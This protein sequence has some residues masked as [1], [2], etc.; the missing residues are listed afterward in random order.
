MTDGKVLR[1]NL[2]ETSNLLNSENLLTSW[3]CDDGKNLVL[4]QPCTNISIISI[5][6]KEYFLGLSERYNLFCNDHVILSNCTSYTIHDEFLLITTTDNT[7]KCLLKDWD[8]PA[9]LKNKLN[10]LTDI[11]S[12]RIEKST[13]ITSS[14]GSTKVI[15]QMPR[16]NLETIHPRPLMLSHICKHLNKLQYREAFDLAKVH[17]ID[18]NLL[19]DY[20]PKEFLENVQA[21]IE[22]I[23]SPSNLTLFLAS[24]KN[25]DV[26]ATMYP[27]AL[28]KKQ[29]T[30]ISPSPDNKIIVVCDAFRK[31]LE[32]KND[33]KFFLTL[34]ATYAKKGETEDALLRLQ[35]LKDTNKDKSTQ[36]LVD[37]ALNFLLYLVDVNELIDIALGTYNLETALMVSQKS[38]KD[39]KEFLEFY[40]N[41]LKMEENY[42]K[43]KID[44]HLKRYK[45]ALQHLSKC[46]DK[47]AEFLALMKNQRLYTDALHLFPS[48]HPHRMLV[49]KE[50]GRYLME[51]RYFDEAGL[52]F[53]SCG[54][55]ER[56][57]MAYKESLNWQSVLQCA[58]DL[59]YSDNKTVALCQEMSEK[60]KSNHRYLDAAYLLEHYV[61]DIEES[62]VTLIEGCEWNSALF[63]MSKYRRKDIA[64]THLK[65]ALLEH[66]VYLTTHLGQLSNDFHKHYERLKFLRNQKQQQ[67]ELADFVRNREDD[68][69]SETS[70]II[71]DASS[72]AE[73]KSITGSILTKKSSKSRRKH[74]LKKYRLK[75]GSPNEDLAHLA[76]LSE[77]LRKVEAMKDS[78]SDTLKTLIQFSYEDKAKS[79]QT[80]MCALIKEIESEIPN[81]WCHSENSN[82]SSD[83]RFGPDSTANSI[84]ASINQEQ[85]SSVSNIRDPALAAPH[86]RNIDVTLQMLR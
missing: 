77:I 53:I 65:P 64:E 75:E 34:M 28:K 50:Y 5:H 68:L 6:D 61:K 33:N 49:W 41:L 13:I 26:C 30:E 83:L 72:Y 59:N 47:F 21:V 8:L 31:Y 70:S 55:N 7:L 25:E 78:F 52:A 11:L 51:K 82:S 10:V 24:L 9:L 20:N 43:Y 44:M 35:F 69:F 46:E 38:Q 40:N 76:A 39:P 60:L 14:N 12:Q 66:H 23:G 63:V 18:L 67:S 3:L 73:S 1:L 56:A 22:Q 79:L 71:D 48:T 85:K 54:K 36:E 81:I 45:K 15:L 2:D 27:L 58:V 19:F 42:R 57:L 37:K 62:I 4:P 17:R 29:K 86:W 32:K 74:E 84:A 80:H 16:G